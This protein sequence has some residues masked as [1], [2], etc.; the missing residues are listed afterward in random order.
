MP[1]VVGSLQAYAKVREQ[2]E[3]EVGGVLLGMSS[4]LLSFDYT[5]T[6]VDAFEV[7]VL[8]YTNQREAL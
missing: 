3:D 7:G 8:L 6:F 1:A 4:E 5:E 2:G